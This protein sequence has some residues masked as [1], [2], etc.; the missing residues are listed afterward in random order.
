MDNQTRGVRHRAATQARSVTDHK[1]G[2]AVVVT[3]RD[4]EV[5]RALAD[6]RWRLNTLLGHGPATLVI[7]VAGVRQISSA[8]IAV[9]LQV[10]RRCRARGVDLVVREPSRRSV[11]MLHRTG[12][13]SALVIESAD[14][15]RLQR[16]E[17]TSRRRRGTR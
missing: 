6:L 9:L 14:G 8:T 1:Y 2:D 3:L 12:L 11:D 17:A 15:A 16:R 4:T 5:P 13:L 10:K 7:D